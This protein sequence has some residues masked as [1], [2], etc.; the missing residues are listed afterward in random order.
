MSPT[1]QPGVLEIIWMQPDTTDVAATK[2]KFKAAM[3]V[4]EPAEGFDGVLF[5]GTIREDPGMSLRILKWS[6]VDVS[7][8]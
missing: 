3:K 8:S 6:S 4:L 5:E 7:Y 2:T 1:K